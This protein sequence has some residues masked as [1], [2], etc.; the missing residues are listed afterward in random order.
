MMEHK[1]EIEIKWN[2]QQE[3]AKLTSVN[4]FEV[5]SCHGRSYFLECI[6]DESA[7]YWVDLIN[8]TKYLVEDLTNQ[9]IDDC[10][11]VNKSISPP[12]SDEEEIKKENSIY[13]FFN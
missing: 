4:S 8:Q 2:G 5:L 6:G 7:E 11:G 12:P 1:G 10:I 13:S 9:E 3:I